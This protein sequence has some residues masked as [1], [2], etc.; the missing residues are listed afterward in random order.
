[1][2]TFTA[3]PRDFADPKFDIAPDVLHA[4]ISAGHKDGFVKQTG[5]TF[6]VLADTASIVPPAVILPFDRL[7]D[8]RA[9]VALRFWRALMG[10]NPGPNPA[11]LSSAR[12]DRLILALRGLDGRLA[13]ATHR[14]K[15]AADTTFRFAQN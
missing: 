3:C 1:M 6:R 10:R 4:L 5:E 2:I 14:H 15:S 8:I 13:G 12:R 7:F 9:A 11:A